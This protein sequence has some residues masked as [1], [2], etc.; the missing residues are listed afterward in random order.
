MKTKD[1]CW[2]LIAVLV[3]AVAACVERPTGPEEAD[4]APVAAFAK[5]SNPGPPSADIPLKVSF[6]DGTDRIRSDG[7]GDYVHKTALVSAVIGDGNGTLY[8]QAFDGKKKDE[9]IRGVEVDL[10][11]QVAVYHQDY[12]DEFE[13]DVIRVETEEDESYDDWPVFTSDVTLHTRSLNG[14]MDAMG[15]TLLDAGKIGFN[16][17]GDETWEWRLLFGARVEI[18]EGVF[19]HFE[20]GLCVTREDGNNWTVANYGPDCAFE[21]ITELWRVVD[22]VFTHV[23]DFN[24]P[25]HLKLTRN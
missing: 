5:P 6:A 18:P 25:M 7:D 23:A 12:L 13:A 3:F 24:T 4:L 1:R 8:F 17:Y 10:G 11:S 2:W 9:P 16:D 14:G 20:E 21:G 22:G 15:A 19:D